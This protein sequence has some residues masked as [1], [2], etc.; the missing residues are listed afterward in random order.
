[1]GVRL[2]GLVGHVR[3]ERHPAPRT[4]LLDGV[5]QVLGDP[6]S[7]QGAEGVPGHG[8][9]R[10]AVALGDDLDRLDHVPQALRLKVQAHGDVRHLHLR[11]RAC[12]RGL[13]QGSQPM[14]CLQSSRACTYQDGLP[15]LGQRVHQSQ[16]HVQPGADAVEKDQGKTPLC[17]HRGGT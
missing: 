1:M 10:H 12:V 11:A 4:Y 15:V 9:V 14:T 5:L 16:V 7:G 3:F 2:V 13:G 8:E 17:T 6:G